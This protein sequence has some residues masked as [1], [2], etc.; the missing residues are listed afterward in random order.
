MT[1]KRIPRR[2]GYQ[3]THIRRDVPRC[4]P[5]LL[6]AYEGQAAATVHEAMGRRGALDPAIKPLAADMTVC[7][8][9]LTVR[10]HT[11]DNLMLVKAVSMAGPGDVIVADM[12]SAVA[13]GP[14]GEVLAV[15]CM[16]RGAA[17]LVVSCTVRDSRE[18]I[19][20]GFPVFSAGLCVRGTAK[21][22]LGTI[23][24]PICIGGEIVR[25][26]DLIVGDADGVVVVP[27]EEAPDILRLA[28]ERTAKEAAVMDRLR[29]GE[30]LFD[31]YGYQR[32]FDSLHCVEE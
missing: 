7:G 28:E 21:A 18:I 19:R 8:R 16:A 23:N 25:P 30:S 14:F 29:A 12:G 27:L 11:G 26:G 22:T 4:D 15:E 2:V 32:V 1:T 10:C 9:A 31:I 6:R 13:S 3:L 24:H 17:G 5:A 20:M